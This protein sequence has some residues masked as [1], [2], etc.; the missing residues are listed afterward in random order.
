MDKMS[1]SYCQSNQC[2]EACDHFADESYASSLK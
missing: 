2:E 1:L